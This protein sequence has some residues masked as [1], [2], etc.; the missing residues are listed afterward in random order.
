MESS[1]YKV[2]KVLA[3]RD[4]WRNNLMFKFDENFG[5]EH[6]V[7]CVLLD[8]QTARYLP[9]TIDVV[10]AIIC[11]TTTEHQEEFDSHYIGF[12]FE[13]LSKE[14]R[15]FNINLEAIMSLDDFTN[16]F[17]Y[18]KAFALVYNVIVLMITLIPREYF[19]N[20]NDDEYRDFAEG[21]RSKFVLD[22]MSKNSLYEKR[23]I[24]A[25]EASVKFIY[26]LPW[27]IVN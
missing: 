8:F 9:I 14:L 6:P 24:E 27:N 25:V 26:K 7:H 21:N 23:L 13:Q 4:I 10:M 19:V 11:T 5:L 22:Y 18:H 15:R 16:S 17:A 3:H 20:F 1:P 2:L 12:Y